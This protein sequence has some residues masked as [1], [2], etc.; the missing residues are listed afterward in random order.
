MK[1]L[2]NSEAPG[3]LDV[4]FFGFFLVFFT[5]NIVLWNNFSFQIW[6]IYLNNFLKK[7]NLLLELTLLHYTFYPYLGE[8]IMKYFFT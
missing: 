2:Y 4:I 6:S 5:T 3:K 8:V 7:K 1:V